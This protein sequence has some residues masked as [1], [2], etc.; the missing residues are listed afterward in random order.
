MIE[1][2]P[3]DM[4]LLEL[5]PLDVLFFRD[6]RPF[7]PASRATSGLPQPQTVA[8]AI[9]TWL[10]ERAGVDFAQ[11]GTALS[12]GASFAD[13][14]ADQGEDAGAIGRLSL[15]G[16]WFVRRGEPLVATPAN[17]EVDDEDRLHRLDPLEKPPPGWVPLINGMKPLW[18][19]ERGATKPR[20]GFL[21]P[22]GLAR[23]L[24]GD[25]PEPDQ[26][27]DEAAV[28]CAEGRVGIGLDSERRTTRK[29]LIYAIR[30]M[31]LMQGVTLSVEVHGVAD[32]LAILP[33]G[34]DLLALGGEARRAVVR[35]SRAY[36]PPS[37][38]QSSVAGNGR[39]VLLTTAGP[40]GGWCPPG[41]KPLAAAVPEPVAVSG[42][43]LAKGGPK[44]NRFA[45]P[46]GSVYF[47]KGDTDLAAF[48]GS[49]AE[50]A[51][52]ALGWGA[53]VEGAWNY[54]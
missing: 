22:T 15:R 3:S 18:R 8:G 52:A 51:D 30:T 5:D 4:V 21:R 20:G 23:Y 25:K 54:A 13:A 48:E 38:A 42:W 35:R 47:L 46:P 44:P 32:D 53:F 19:S 12:V 40:F 10:L 43:D 45:A 2:M 7:E 27:L 37:V 31:R 33:D 26:V 1:R 39:L 36:D 16:P 28:F 34:E 17:I 50:P 6:G 9:R 14:V 11:L 24:S 41:L 49:L 29:G